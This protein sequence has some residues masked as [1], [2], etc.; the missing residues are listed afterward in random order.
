MWRW[1]NGPS[2][3]CVRTGTIGPKPTPLGTST[4]AWTTASPTWPISGRRAKSSSPMRSTTIRRPAR[5][6]RP[7][8]RDRQRP[9][10]HLPGVGRSLRQGRRR[11]HLRRD[12]PAGPRAVDDPKVS[13]VVGDGASL[14]RSR[15]V[16]R[17]GA[18]V[19]RVPTHLRRH[20][21]RGVPSRC[22]AGPAARRRARLPVEQRARRPAVAS[23][24]G[25]AVR[26]AAAG[27]GEAMERHDAAFLG[28]KV[29]LPRIRKALRVWRPPL[30]GT[31]G[32]GTLYAWAWATATG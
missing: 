4:P 17:P 26:P 29:P 2:T 1:V 15:P 14:P 31:R 3:V 27:A 23:P 13:F 8:R 19:H 22:R 12:G 7:G 32:E 18:V 30:R 24:P 28:T 21:H 6:P 25:G 20:R 9:R 5:R 16:R 11:G 10:S